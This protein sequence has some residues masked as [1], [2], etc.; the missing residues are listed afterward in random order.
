MM[1]K[2]KRGFTLAEVLVTLSIIAIMAAVLLPAL[3]SQIGKGDAGRVA[4][5]LT[6]IQTG[7]QAFL[8]DVHRYPASLTHL[9]TAIATNQNDLLGSAYPSTLVAKWKGPY[10]QKDAI[11]PSGI[12]TFTS[13]FSQT[14]GSNGINYLSVSLTNVSAADFARIED[15]LDEGNS[16]STSSTSGLVRYSSTNSTLTYLALPIQ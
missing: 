1:K 5:D 11:S 4:S 3:N 12:G 2:Q 8:S 13:T 6:N 9:T 15:L 16:S 7:A 10:V 14:A